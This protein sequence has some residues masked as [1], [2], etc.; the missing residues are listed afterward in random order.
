MGT[1]AAVITARK[2]SKA[3]QAGKVYAAQHTLNNLFD[4]LENG[5]YPRDKKIHFKADPLALVITQRKL[6]KPMWEIADWLRSDNAREILALTEDVE[7]ANDI[8]R[9]YRNKLMMRALKYSDQKPTK[10]RTDL[11]DYVESEDPYTIYANDIPMI[12]KLPEFYLE[13]L[14]MD[15]LKK[16]Y[17][18]NEA[19]YKNHS[20]T[21]RLRPL[22][23]HQRKTS[24]TDS[25]NFWFTDIAGCIYK[26][27]ID[28]KNQLLH[29]F[30]RVI[31]DKEYVD[32]TATFNKTKVRGQDYV[33]YTPNSW[34]IT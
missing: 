7:R 5:Q 4:D 32:I 15:E 24:R 26:F 12:V 19:S 23:K 1:S 29:L 13:D 8:K 14:M 25:V 28:P 9:Y 18:M 27:S 33:Y 20:A 3:Y 10:F 6:G 34:S 31:Y 2:Q 11:R 22:R 17:S 16:E 21:T 30:E